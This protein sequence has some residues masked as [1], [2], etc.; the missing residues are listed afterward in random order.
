MHQSF[1]PGFSDQLP[2]VLLD[3]ELD[4]SNGTRLIGRLLESDE[5]A[6]QLGAR[7]AVAWE[8]LGGQI[9]IPAYVLQEATH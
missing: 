9:R 2:F 8:E 3:V 6:L 7:V 1:L 4:A 5:T